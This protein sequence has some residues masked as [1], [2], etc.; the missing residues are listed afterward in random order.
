MPQCV[1]PEPTDIVVLQIETAFVLR[2]PDAIRRALYQLREWE[3]AAKAKTKR[4][5][6]SG[7]EALKKH[8]A[9][10]Q[11]LISANNGRYSPRLDGPTPELA[12]RPSNR[13][14]IASLLDAGRITADQAMAAREIQKIIEIITRG[15]HAKCQTY[16]RGSNAGGSLSGLMPAEAAY[17]WSQRYVP[18]HAALKAKRDKGSKA[19]AEL[20]VIEG[21]SLDMA[22]R[23]MRMS[24]ER[25]HNY[26]VD[27]LDLYIEMRQRDEA[28]DPDRE[29]IKAREAVYG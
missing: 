23:K 1:T 10:I 27:A 24:Y 15:S 21:Y 19:I 12:S 18:W 8:C 16:Q 2:K 17:R 6:F 5:E 11:G 28:Y 29:K 7:A 9:H 14:S 26:L 22:R 4:K 3:T 25:G 13:D 20:V